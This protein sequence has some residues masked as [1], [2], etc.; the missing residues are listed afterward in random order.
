[1]GNTP[2]CLLS[3]RLASEKVCL[4]LLDS[5]VY[6]KAAEEGFRRLVAVTNNDALN[7]LIANQASVHLEPDCIYRVPSSPHDEQIIRQS[8]FPARIAFSNTLYSPDMIN[9]LAN[10]EAS[11]ELLP[12]HEIGPGSVPLLEVVEKGEG[13]RI[14]GTGD[15]PAGQSL[16]YV[17]Q[18]QKK[19]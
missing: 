17:P 18:N 13:L 19:S 4:D 3:Q 15:H 11:L 8:S 6:E 10:K 7:E 14:L 16:C 1:M 5:D 12:P 2:T 9:A